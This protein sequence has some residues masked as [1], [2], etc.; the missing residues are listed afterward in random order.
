MNPALSLFVFI[1]AFGWD[2][3]EESRFLEGELPVRR[4]LTTELGYSSTC[5]PTILTGV[6]P[7]E[8]GHFTFYYYA[9]EASPFGRL[10]ALAVLPKA[11]TSRAR[12]RHHLSRWLQPRLGYTGYFA[13][14][15]MPFRHIHLFAYSERRD[16]YEPGGIIGGQPTVFDELRAR[17]IPYARSDW[18]RPDE[19]NLES[20]HSVLRHGNVRAAY[21]YLAGMDGAMHRY[22]TRGA[23]TQAW[24]ELYQ[25]G[26]RRLMTAAHARYR[27]VRVHVF[28]DHGMSD[29]RACIDIQS[30]LKSTGLTF[31]EDYVVAIDS[32]MARFWFLRQGARLKIETALQG[33][34]GGQVLSKSDLIDMCCDFPGQRY[35]ELFFLASPGTLISPSFMGARP[36]RGMHGYDPRHA[37][38]R[39][40]YA[41]SVASQQPNSLRDLHHVMLGSAAA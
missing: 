33:L 9:P 13:L 26:L 3:L 4:P 21:L 32:T 6:S 37:D 29:V 25:S 19:E 27:D 7:R 38:T 14:Y 24:L 31:G 8:H 20:M 34:V 1:D 28:S 11:L 40:M 16:L 22:G 2:L 39:A 30:T 17:G 12:F 15:N 18:R 10:R 5:D 23:R 36:V 41:S 35:G